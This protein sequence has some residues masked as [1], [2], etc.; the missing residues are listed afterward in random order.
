MPTGYYK[1]KKPDW[2][3]GKPMSAEQKQKISASEKGR[4]VSE[5]TRAKIAHSLKGHTVSE[6]TK[7]RVR[8][9]QTGRMRERAAHW[10]GGRYTSSK[11]YVRVYAPDHPFAVARSYVLE[12]RLVL[13]KRLGRYLLPSEVGHHKDGVKDNNEDGN[14]HLCKTNSEHRKLHQNMYGVVYALYRMGIVGFE[15]GQYVIK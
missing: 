8:E 11:G 12:H 15:G 7:D 14:L 1:R 4:L 3:K 9:A 13:E 10:K 5:E 6:E 2:N